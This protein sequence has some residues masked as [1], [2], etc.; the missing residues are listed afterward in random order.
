[1]L[2]DAAS[3]YR[4]ALIFAAEPAGA[5]QALDWLRRAAE[6]GHRDAQ[7]RLAIALEEGR[8]T[9]ADPAQAASWYAKAAQAEDAEA[10][11]RLALLYDEGI[12]VPRD[13]V[14]A[15]DLLGEAMG[16]GHNG[17]QERLT[18][19]LGPSPFQWDSGD[20]FKGLR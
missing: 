14:K 17:A 1:M 18:R 6:Q 16:L 2:A 12:G 19:L 8:G 13:T 3:Q 7:L 20:L 5:A 15:R 11:Y 9:A 10:I 4:I